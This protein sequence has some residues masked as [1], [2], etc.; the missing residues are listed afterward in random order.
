MALTGTISPGTCLSGME[1]EET[2]GAKVEE[3][4]FVIPLGNPEWVGDGL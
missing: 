2:P 1:K 3:S 4:Y